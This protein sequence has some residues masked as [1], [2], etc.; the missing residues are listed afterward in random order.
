VLGDPNSAVHVYTAA[1]GS[2]T[3]KANATDEDGTFTAAPFAVQVT[4]LAPLAVSTFTQTNAGFDV[5]F[6]RAI[7]PCDVEFVRRWRCRA[8]LADVAAQRPERCR[9]RLA[10]A[11][12]GPSGLAFREDRRAAG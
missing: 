7:D 4:P 8:R 2:Y 5:R 11:R 10:A 9:P 1:P 6:N 3:I 12:C